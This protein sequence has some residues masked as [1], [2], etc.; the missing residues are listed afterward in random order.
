MK[1]L[2]VLSITALISL[3]ACQR[4]SDPITPEPTTEQKVAGK[5][6][7]QKVNIDYYTPIS[8]L[9]D[10][11]EYIGGPADSLV[12]KPGGLVYSYD[13]SPAPEILSYSIPD[14][15]HIIIDGERFLIKELNTAKF[16]IYSDSV[17]VAANERIVT[18]V[19][20]VR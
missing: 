20:M 19:Y 9:N 16:R 10:T 6:K 11:Q 12:F 7:L 2:F 3:T 8:V 13:G 17:D 15:M 5:W 14:N 18:D 1:T 4:E